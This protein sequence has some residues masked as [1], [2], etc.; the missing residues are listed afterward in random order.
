MSKVGNIKRKRRES[1]AKE[2]SRIDESLKHGFYIIDHFQPLLF[3]QCISK[4]Q[5][6]VIE[7][8]MIKFLEKLPKPYSKPKYGKK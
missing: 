4:N 5:L 7:R 3:A 1:I 8:P 2:E 6:L